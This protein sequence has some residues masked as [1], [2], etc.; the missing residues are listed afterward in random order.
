[1]PNTNHIGLRALVKKLSKKASRQ[2]T[3][4]APIFKAVFVGGYVKG[5]KAKRING[6]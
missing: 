2:W 4:N 1:M 6:D 5:Y 3:V